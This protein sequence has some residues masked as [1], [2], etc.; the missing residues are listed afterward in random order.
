MVHASTYLSE[1]IPEN[2]SARKS[3]QQQR[4]LPHSTRHSETGVREPL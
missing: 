1:I 3:V 2:Q 4:P